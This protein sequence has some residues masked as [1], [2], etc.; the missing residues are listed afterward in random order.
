M[1]LGSFQATQRAHPAS[2]Q[3]LTLV[4]PMVLRELSQPSKG[5]TFGHESLGLC[6]AQAQELSDL[7]ESL[8]D[9]SG[10]NRWSN[11]KVS[12]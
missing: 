8:R 4:R 3:A 5:L 6:Q 10:K 2:G 7:L 9:G 1:L 11:A 12:F